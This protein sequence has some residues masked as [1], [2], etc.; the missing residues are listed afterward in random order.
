[1][2][3]VLRS[4]ALPSYKR[5]NADNSS[6]IWRCHLLLSVL[7]LLTRPVRDDHHAPLSA[8]NAAASLYFGWILAVCCWLVFRDFGPAYEYKAPPA[9][10]YW[11]G[12]ITA[13]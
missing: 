7:P 4:A 8:A 9:W 2:V 12:R 5:S 10:E 6:A 1:M 11:S 3:R 13:R